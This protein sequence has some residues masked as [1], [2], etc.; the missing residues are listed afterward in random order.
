MDNG[1]MF[2]SETGNIRESYLRTFEDTMVSKVRLY[3]TK[4]SKD[5]IIRIYEI[6]L[7]SK[8]TE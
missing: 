5:V 2:F 7:N 6:H 1:E 8:M 4:V 3:F